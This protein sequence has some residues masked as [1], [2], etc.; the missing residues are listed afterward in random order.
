M[1]H[2]R[3]NTS[4][5]HVKPSRSTS[6]I[7][8]WL[9]NVHSNSE[10]ASNTRTDA[11]FVPLQKRMNGLGISLESTHISLFPPELADCD[12]S[13]DPPRFLPSKTSY[14]RFSTFNGPSPTE[15]L[16]SS[17]DTMGYFDLPLV[18]GHSASPAFPSDSKELPS[19][20]K[21]QATRIESRM[22]AS[23]FTSQSQPF[24]MVNGDIE[25]E[26]SLHCRRT[27]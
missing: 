7:L 10:S 26:R 4:S 27:E 1:L 5:G 9:Q 24:L 21:I 11:L 22:T 15:S 17:T 12:P 16:A 18:Q 25:A 23:T 14:P 20:T 3:C 2:H 13:S 6:P 8:S 19:E